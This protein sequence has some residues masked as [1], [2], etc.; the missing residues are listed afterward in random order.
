MFHLLIRSAI[1]LKLIINQIFQI[2]GL[3]LKINFKIVNG[4]V[5]KAQFVD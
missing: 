3:D 2:I 1:C 5:Y 4:I